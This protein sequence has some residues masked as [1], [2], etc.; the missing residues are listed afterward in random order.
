MFCYIETT[1]KMFK[2]N[3]NTFCFVE[4]NNNISGLVNTITEPELKTEL[5]CVG[6]CMFGLS[7]DYLPNQQI[8][9]KTTKFSY[10]HYIL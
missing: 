5:P 1:L 9:R 3:L 10:Y 8:F 7:N 4:D 6:G 2:K